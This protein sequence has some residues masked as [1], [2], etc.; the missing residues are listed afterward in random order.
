MSETTSAG[1]SSASNSAAI[2]SYKTL[3]DDYVK[4][5]LNLSTGAKIGIGVGAGIVG[6]VIIG[7]IIFI[8][9]RLRRSRSNKSGESNTEGKG[10][11]ETSLTEEQKAAEARRMRALDNM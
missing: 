7:M 4:N 2:E 6:L 9:I 1:P 5:G 10:E 8:A 11:S 3:V